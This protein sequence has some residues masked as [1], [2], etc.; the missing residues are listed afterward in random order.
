MINKYWLNDEKKTKEEEVKKKK[1]E[2]IA[3]L[4]FTYEELKDLDTVTKDEYIRRILNEDAEVAIYCK[5]VAQK[6]NDL[7]DSLVEIGQSME[8][9]MDDWD[10][11]MKELNDKFY[12]S[13]LDKGITR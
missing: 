1:E 5:N 9:N 3:K 8:D 12:Q 11:T 10:S 2:E 13:A 6:M 7:E 4:D